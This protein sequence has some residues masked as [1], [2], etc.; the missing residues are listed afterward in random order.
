MKANLKQKE[1]VINREGSPSL[2]YSVV[3][4]L[5]AILTLATPRLGALDPNSSKFL[6][7][8]VFNLVIYLFLITK[9]GVSSDYT[10][11]RKWT[12][13]P[14]G[15]IY[16]ALLFFSVLSFIKSVNIIESIVQFSKIFTVFFSTFNLFIIFRKDK[17]YLIQLIILVNILLIVDGLVV[18]YDIGRYISGGLASIVDINFV[19]SNKNVFASAVFVKIPCALWLMIYGKNKKKLLGYVGLLCA[20][21]STLFLSARAFYLGLIILSVIL[22]A[23]L[24]IKFF[25]LGNRQFLKVL[26]IYFPILIFAFLT[27]T[28]FQATLYPHEKSTYNTNIEERL[29]TVMESK[30]PSRDLRLTAWRNTMQL[31]RENPLLGIGLGN[32]KITELRLDNKTSPTY[33]SMY[34]NH[35]DFLEITAETGIFGGMAF[36]ALFIFPVLFFLK[37]IRTKSPDQEMK[38]L[39]IPMLGLFCYSVDAFFNFP[40]DRVEMQFFF[41]FYIAAG[42]ALYRQTKR[43]DKTSA[44]IAIPLL[45]FQF[46]VMISSVVVLSY[47]FISQRHQL[48]IQKEMLSEKYQSN[49]DFVI[50]GF[51]FIPNINAVGES[52]EVI[53]GFYLYNDGRYEEA[54]NV[55]R[56]DK[57]SP[58]ETRRYLFMAYSFEKLGNSDS[59]AFYFDKVCKEKPKM[60]HGFYRICKLFESKGDWN[61]CIRYMNTF[62]HDVKNDDK[63]WYNYS[64]VLEKS[65]DLKRSSVIIDTALGYLPGD[66]LLILRKLYLKTKLE[67]VP[68]DN[69]LQVGYDLLLKKEYRKAILLLSEIIKKDTTVV[70]SYE[71]RGYCFYSLAE[72]KKSLDDY[73]KVIRSD[74]QKGELHNSVGACYHLLGNDAEACRHFEIGV[75]LGNSDSK[76]NYEKYCKK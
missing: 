50:N 57:A 42:I 68:Y 69:Q 34:K 47:N 13:N 51:P 7:L 65:G 66:T 58:N 49:A 25:V 32:W 31:I 70:K 22:T 30:E 39:F 19:Y 21:L 28:F 29:S 67:K 38:L 41:A 71:Y 26:F 62:L 5:Y 76:T 17:R 72:Y 36:I 14:I 23:F 74:P 8:A 46:L 1:Q 33:T 54:I 40:A 37:L 11:K 56:K 10:Y 15:V 9:H 35:N 63:A 44:G 24:L 43:N 2:G 20:V 55:L 59:A 4:F 6:M 18:F 53:K 60:Y 48:I 16:L 64:Y 12:K 3:I 52:I 45:V 73:L 27:F 75:K 61:S